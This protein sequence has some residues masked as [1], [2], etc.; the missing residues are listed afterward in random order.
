LGNIIRINNYEILELIPPF[1]LSGLS[2]SNLEAAMLNIYPIIS[3]KLNKNKKYNEKYFIDNSEK[4]LKYIINKLKNQDDINKLFHLD[5]NPVVSPSESD[6][7]NQLT[8]LKR[9]IMNGMDSTQ[10]YSASYKRSKEHF[11]KMLY[12]L[13][14]NEI[15]FNTLFDSDMICFL[16]N[17]FNYFQFFR[18]LSLY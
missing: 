17:K 11:L 7:F 6:N 8:M 4:I 1:I 13:S 5:S 15:L 9:T 16:V 12:F 2:R 14:K 10:D 3:E 18:K